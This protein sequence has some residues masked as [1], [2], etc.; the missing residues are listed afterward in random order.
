MRFIILGLC[1]IASFAFADECI[2]DNGKVSYVIPYKV[3]NCKIIEKNDHDILI[4][5]TVSPS[6]VESTNLPN[7]QDAYSAFKNQIKIN[8]A[9]YFCKDSNKNS[10][11]SLIVN[12]NDQAGEYMFTHKVTY[13]DCYH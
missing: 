13:S 1:F 9:Q 8:M 10:D 7:L 11:S 4:D 2:Y 12:V 5:L 3:K 6:Y